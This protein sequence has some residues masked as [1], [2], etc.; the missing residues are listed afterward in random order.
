MRFLKNEK[1]IKNKIYINFYLKSYINLI[2][3]LNNDQQEREVD[4]RYLYLK[5]QL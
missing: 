3:V 5:S 1:K 4:C 2:L